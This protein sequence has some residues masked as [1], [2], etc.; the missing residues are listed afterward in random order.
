MLKPDFLDCKMWANLPI[1]LAGGGGT[2]FLGR[3]NSR[4]RGSLLHS[5]P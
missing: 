1:L 5:L 2:A 3:K 4:A